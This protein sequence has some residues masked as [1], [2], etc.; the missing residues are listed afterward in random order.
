MEL[1]ADR[2]V[3]YRETAGETLTGPYDVVF[4]TVGALSLPAGRAHAGPGRTLRAAELRA[5]LTWATCGRRAA[6]GTRSS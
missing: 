6:T 4:D 1:G 2:F 3:D 5:D